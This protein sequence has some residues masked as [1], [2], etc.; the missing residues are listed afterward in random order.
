MKNF[1]SYGAF[2]SATAGAKSSYLASLARLIRLKHRYIKFFQAANKNELVIEIGCGSGQFLDVLKKAGFTKVVGVEPSPSYADIPKDVSIHCSDAISYLAE[3]PDGTVGTIVA[4]DVLEH[5]PK[6]DLVTLFKVMADR[7]LPGGLVIFRVP[8]MASPLGLFNY[9]GDLTHVTGLNE[10]SVQQLIFNTELRIE[11]IHEEPLA[12][13]RT[14]RMLLGRILWV[15]YRQ[16]LL[17]LFSAFGIHPR[18]ITPNLICILK[19]GA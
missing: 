2:K 5:I 3:V 7:L 4:M 17:T 16:V 11:K 9:Y 8:N 6:D 1:E 18:A 19:K 13:P 12:R 14:L 10:V 15:L